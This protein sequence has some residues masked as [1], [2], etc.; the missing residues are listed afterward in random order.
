[1]KLF[2]P[3]AAFFRNLRTR[4]RISVRDPHDDRERWYIFLSPLNVLT[5]LVAL[6]VVLGVAAL[7]IVAFTPALDLVPGYQGSKARG[8]LIRY[9]LRLDSLETRLAQWNDYYENLTRI[10]DGQP[11]LGVEISVPDSLSTPAA[12][13]A[14]IPEDSILRR[15]LEGTGPYGLQHAVAARGNDYPEMYPPVKGVVIRKFDPKNSRYGTDV[16]TTADQPV[17]A[18]MDGTVINAGWTPTEGY[19]IYIL[20]PGGFLSAILQNA[21]L[22]KKT[23]DRVYS[24][25]VVAFTGSAIASAVDAGYTQVQLWINGTPVDPENYMIF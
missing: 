25:E 8:E 24:G 13:V 2:A 18:L 21:R 10:M 1:M 6:V 9:N 20:H 19:L 5:A 15:Q 4:L 12:N 7:S 14:R 3:I 16:A 11:P 17:M 22:T 23:G